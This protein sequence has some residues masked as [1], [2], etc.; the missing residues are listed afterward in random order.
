VTGACAVP[1]IPVIDTSTDTSTATGTNT[2]TSTATFTST[3]TGTDTNTDPG[4]APDP[5]AGLSAFPGTLNGE[6]SVSPSGA[7]MYKV[8]IALPPGI[9]G[10]VPNL[11]LVYSSQGANGIAGQGWDLTGLSMIHRCPKTR[12]EDSYAR[13]VTLSDPLVGDSADGI[14]L[15]G[16]RLFDRGANS[17]GTGERYEPEISD[18]SDITLSTD[19]SMFTVVTKSGETRY[20]GMDDKARVRVAGIDNPAPDGKTTA[21]W[22]LQKV[23]DVWGNYY[24]IHYNGDHKDFSTS[25]IIVSQIEYTGRLAGSASDGEAAAVPT[26]ESIKFGYEPRPD[27]RTG[28]FR[29]AAIPRNLRLTRIITDI[30]VYKLDYAQ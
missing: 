1:E 14:C 25:G 19:G 17:D 22:L 9:A 3:V 21:I 26:F 13:P 5:T 18:F 29:S 20:Y 23:V 24:E 15:D 16:K 30:G 7:A 8:P 11:A 27:V 12:A 10:M 2:D 6:L 4:Q 28:R